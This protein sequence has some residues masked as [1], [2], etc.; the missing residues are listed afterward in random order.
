LHEIYGNVESILSSENIA[1]TVVKV[2]C[3]YY[4]YSGTTLILTSL[5]IVVVYFIAHADKSCVSITVNHPSLCVILSV[6]LYDKTRTAVTKITI[7]GQGWKKPMVF[8][9][10]NLFFWFLWFFNVV[11]GLSLE[12]QNSLKTRLYTDKGSVV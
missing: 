6:C 3:Q 5:I 9:I 2:Y 10:R 1:F 12:S 11:L 8:Q 4:C 7:L